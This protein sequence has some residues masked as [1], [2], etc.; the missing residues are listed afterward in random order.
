VKALI[1]AAG[2]ATRLR[3]LTD[4]IPKQLLPVGGRPIVDWILDRIAETSVDEIHLVTN[5]RFAAEF[6]RWADGKGVLVHNDGTTSNEDRLGAIGDIDFVGVDDDLLAIAGDNLFDYSLADY[7]SYW[8][9]KG[10]SCVA[11]H[12]VGDR[13]LAKQYGIVEVDGDDRIVGF[14]EKPADPPSTLAATATYLYRREHAALV[15]EYLAEGNPPDQPGNLVA[16]LHRRE[17]VYAYRFPG[18]WYDIGDH[19]QLLEA[20]NRTRRRAGLPE[21][22][23]YTPE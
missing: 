10:G 23:V 2:Y 15:P 12:D 19:A 6:E 5:G 21:R 16:W 17:P 1:L 11:V 22:T 20:D 9:E 8:R 3:P 14:V 13:E 18:E 4:S 7:E